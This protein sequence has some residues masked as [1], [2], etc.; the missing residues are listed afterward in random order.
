MDD[1]TWNE[2]IAQGIEHITYNKDDKLPFGLIY[3]P[4]EGKIYWTCSEDKDGKITSVFSN[5]DISKDDEENPRNIANYIPDVV[6]AIR[7]KNEL[8][9]N[10]WT[11]LKT[12]LKKFYS[13]GME[14]DMN[15]KKNRDRLEKMMEKE[16]K[17]NPAINKELQDI[18][19]VNRQLSGGVP[20]KTK[21]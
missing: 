13:K 18:K 11:L 15:K 12:P 20:K 7:I 6:E 2:S 9:A 4:S 16:A 8:I 1:D 3:P 14:I 17:K 5:D 19:N 21:K 10:G